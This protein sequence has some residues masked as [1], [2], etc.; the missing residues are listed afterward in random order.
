MK[1]ADFL[2]Y[3]V[4]FPLPRVNIKQANDLLYTK[5]IL[6]TLSFPFSSQRKKQVRCSYEGKIFWTLMWLKNKV[7]N[8]HAWTK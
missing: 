3:P 4:T 7:L 1:T 8:L 6:L 5:N 2:T